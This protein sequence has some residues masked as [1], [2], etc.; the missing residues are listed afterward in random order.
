MSDD[1]ADH[2]V[3]VARR[4]RSMAPAIV[5]TG[6]R[7]IDARDLATLGAAERVSIEHA[8]HRRKV[9]FA[10]GRHLLRS[11]IGA[12]TDLPIAASRAPAWP[13]AVR[14]SL[15]HDRTMV[16][17]AITRATPIGAIGIDLEPRDQPLD[18]AEADLV[19]RDD[20]HAPDV[21]SAFVMK[22][23]TY[24]AWSGL[25][26]RVLDHHDVR[27]DADG[28]HFTATVL[29]DGA[30]FDGT[31]AAVGDRWVALV[32]AASPDAARPV[33]DQRVPAPS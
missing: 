1:V 15:A 10:S 16:I 31:V 28:E 7:A 19:L 25:G 13:A 23:A 24:K 3:E 8:V 4:L 9:E 26:G 29:A 33:A 11:L 27:V 18:D 21:I 6:A 2:V 14:G 12:P 5:R 22:E 32:I 30:K 17:A 20:D